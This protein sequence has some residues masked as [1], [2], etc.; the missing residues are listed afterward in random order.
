MHNLPNCDNT[1]I[2]ILVSRRLAEIVAY[3]ASVFLAF[4]LLIA[5]F[6]HGVFVLKWKRMLRTSM[7]SLHGHGSYWSS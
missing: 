6:G 3:Y 4:L 7:R 5:I 2:L 1:R